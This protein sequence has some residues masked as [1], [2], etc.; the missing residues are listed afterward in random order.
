MDIAKDMNGRP[1]LIGDIILYP[2]TGYIPKI[3]QGEVVSV[4][5]GKSP[6]GHGKNWRVGIKEDMPK[7]STWDKPV[8]S[9]AFPSIVW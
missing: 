6:R 1:I 3:G 4:K 7:N 9:H 8:K 5:I 2:I